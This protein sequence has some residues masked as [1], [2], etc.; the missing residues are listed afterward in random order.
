M[1]I[2]KLTY[3]LLEYICCERKEAMHCKHAITDWYRY[4]KGEKLNSK[5]MEV[6]YG[7]TENIVSID[8]G[9]R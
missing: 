4:I 6:K 7:M 9:I 3:I 8:C 1:R 5:S 2:I